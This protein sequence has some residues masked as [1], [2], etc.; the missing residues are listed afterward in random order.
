[1][2]HSSKHLLAGKTVIIHPRKEDASSG[3][4][5]GAEYEL[6]DYWD[7]LTGGSWMD[8]EGNPAALKYAFRAGFGGIEMDDEVVY[9]KIRSG[10]FGFGNLIHVSELGEVAPKKEK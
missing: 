10:N 7:T 6:E 8:A 3:I 1:M 9:G 4:V 2:A 5:D